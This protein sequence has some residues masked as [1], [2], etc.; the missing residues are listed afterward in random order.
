[1]ADLLSDES[2][3]RW[4]KGDA[5]NQEQLRWEAWEQ[6]H[7][8]HSQLKRKARLLYDIPMEEAEPTDAEEQLN[9]LNGKINRVNFESHHTSLNNGYRMAVAAGL[10]VILG[11]IAFLSFHFGQPDNSGHAPNKYKTVHAGYG[12]TASLKIGDGISIRLNANST[13]KYESGQLNADSVE[14]WLKGEGYFSIIHNPNRI[15]VV[16]TPDGNITDIGTQFNVN[17]RFKNTNVVLEKGKVG[18]SLSEPDK[19]S[20]KGITMSS[21]FKA[22]LNSSLNKIR[23]QKVNTSLYT[24][25]LDG[26]L[27]FNNTSLG[28]VVL[29]IE[30]TY[31]I[32]LSVKDPKLL[33]ERVSGS[34]RNPDLNT[35]IQGLE[36]ALNLNFKKLSED[37]Y[38]ITVQN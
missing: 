16:H 23:L 22:T 38:L 9:K 7:A 37:K 21:G 29:N 14:V 2:F 6:K 18:L 13:L 31:G 19:N 26:R 35:L 34:L 4:I 27:R 8:R 32:S 33:H 36:K 1:M 17:T 12:Q 3:V 5:G 30:S 11:V 20:T 24:A 15:F 25:W 28:D 10:I